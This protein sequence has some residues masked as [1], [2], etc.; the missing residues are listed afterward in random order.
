[1]TDSIIER[2][3]NGI[4][5]ARYAHTAT[6]DTPSLMLNSLNAVTGASLSPPRRRSTNGSRAPPRH[7]P[8]YPNLQG[9][10][11]ATANP[12]GAEIGA[13]RAYDPDG[14]QLIGTILNTA[15]G[16]LDYGWLGSQQRPLEHQDGLQPVVE[17]GARQY[18]PTIGRFLEVD[19]LEAG[20]KNDYAYAVD[21][22]NTADLS[23]EYV[24]GWCMAGS[25][26][27]FWHRR[28]CMCT[29]GT[30]L[31]PKT[32]WRSRDLLDGWL[33]WRLEFLLRGSSPT[34]RQW[35]SYE[36]SPIV[37]RC[38]SLGGPG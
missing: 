29:L 25:A 31:C 10:L 14:N 22:V 3:V 23:G 16:Q 30:I 27:P 20:T 32:W 13:T 18:Q 38:P 6:G 1:M 2:R 19:P 36:G 17:M 12:S 5:E 8:S 7:R 34:H 35:R 26:V 33:A 11:T 28:I 37:Q 4:I 15:P 24:A 9:S 21:P